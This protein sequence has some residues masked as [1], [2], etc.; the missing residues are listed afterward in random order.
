MSHPRF[1][2]V[3][4]SLSNNYACLNAPDGHVACYTRPY[5]PAFDTVYLI[6]DTGSCNITFITCLKC[7]CEKYAPLVN[8]ETCSET[9]VV[10]AIALANR[11]SGENS[12]GVEVLGNPF[13]SSSYEHC[14]DIDPGFFSCLFDHGPPKFVCE[15]CFSAADSGECVVTSISRAASPLLE[16]SGCFMSGDCHC[17]FCSFECA[18]NHI[19]SVHGIPANEI[20]EPMVRKMCV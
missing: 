3:F 10:E 13:T 9:K 15:W 17:L 1:S 16:P 8:P 19:E 12:G 6:R 7:W 20:T 11:I 2:L 5:I 18:T 4:P 14:V